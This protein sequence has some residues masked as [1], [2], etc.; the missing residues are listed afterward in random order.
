MS[1]CTRVRSPDP[2]K[3]QLRTLS[4]CLF[5]CFVLF[6]QRVSIGIIRLVI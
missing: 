4:V 3:K 1:F 5:V 2:K 6:S